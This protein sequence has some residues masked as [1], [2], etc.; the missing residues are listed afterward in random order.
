MRPV[1]LHVV[2]RQTGGVPVAVRTMIDNSVEFAEHH[3]IVGQHEGEHF[4]WG[5][6]FQSLT[7]LPRDPVR[8]SRSI[9]SRAAAIEASH[10]HAHSS[11]PG[12]YARLSNSARR[13]GRTLVYSPHCFAFERRDLAGPVRRAYRTI[14]RVLT[15]RT[16][17]LAACSPGEASLAREIGHPA[18][19]VSYVPNTT[20]HRRQAQRT[21]PV[22]GPLRIVGLG[23]LSA[24]KGVDYFARV[25]A[26]LRKADR[27]LEVQWLGGG[28]EPYPAMLRDVGVEVS[29]WLPAPE[30]EA[31][32]ASADLYLHTAAWEGFPLAV[33]EAHFAGLPIL[34]RPIRAFGNIAPSM[35]I[36]DVLVGGALAV[37]GRWAERNFKDW[38]SFLSRNTPD[39]QAAALRSIYAADDDGE[40]A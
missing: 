9:R 16:D 3:L 38:R 30:V 32:L 4:D 8:A 17:V 11:C 15:Q 27:P 25:V 19:R 5:G 29:G 39:E 13:D 24:Q 18:K 23:R 36:H 7:V 37:D 40:Y 20:R 21:W 10:I 22:E 2:D 28:D 1:V 12:T 14:E 33:I 6:S 34:V 26:S 31:R 35:S